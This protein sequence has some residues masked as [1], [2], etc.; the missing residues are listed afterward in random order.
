MPTIDGK[1]I[2]YPKIP[3]SGY[4]LKTADDVRRDAAGKGRK[5]NPNKSEK[6]SGKSKVG[7]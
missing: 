3:K 6:M 4:G 1:K 5:N 7:Y 2:P